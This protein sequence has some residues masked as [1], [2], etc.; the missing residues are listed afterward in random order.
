V[1]GARS[2]RD[3]ANASAARVTGASK[4]ERARLLRRRATAASPERATASRHHF[5]RVLQNNL[6][7]ENAIK[8]LNFVTFRV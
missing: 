7:A 3:G 5:C 8:C 4:L 2:A 1:P 6:Q